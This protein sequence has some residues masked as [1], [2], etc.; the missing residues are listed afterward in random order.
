MKKL[1]QKF[2]TSVYFD[3]LG[4]ALVMCVAISFGYLNTRLDKYVDWGTWAAYVPFGFI[5]VVN[6]GVSMLSTRF[7][8]KLNAV[9][10]VFGIVN[11]VITGVID[12]ILG[13]KA[14]IITYPVTFLIYS[15]AIYKWQRSEAG[16]ANSLPIQRLQIIIPILIVASF[17]FSI[18]ANYVGFDGQI[19]ILSVTTTLTFALSLVANCLN[20]FKVTTQWHFWLVYNFIQIVKAVVQGNFANV[21]KYIFYVINCVGATFVWSDSTKE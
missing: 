3:I 11:A 12:Y 8:G 4:V 7:T 19:T 1:L 5:S 2:A 21:G 20:A 13:N 6:V 18:I 10:N 16:K 15:I 14:A 17:V 9:G